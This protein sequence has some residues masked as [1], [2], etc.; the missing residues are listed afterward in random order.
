MEI[1]LDFIVSI[2]DSLKA[3]GFFYPSVL[4]YFIDKT[5]LN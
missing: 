1:M 2:Y 4:L 3:V 5:K